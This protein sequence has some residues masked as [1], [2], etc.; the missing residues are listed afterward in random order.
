MIFPVKS[1]DLQ[2]RIN[3]E[4]NIFKATLSALL[5]S[6]DLYI[7]FIWLDTTNAMYIKESMFYLFE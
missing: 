6:L 4:K 7:R 3:L 2:L 5:G 1:L